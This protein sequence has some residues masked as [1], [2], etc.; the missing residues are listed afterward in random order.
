[1]H[2]AYKCRFYPSPEPA[3]QF[4]KIFGSVR[5][6]DNWGL[7]TKEDAYRQQ[8]KG[9]GFKALCAKLPPLKHQAETVWLHEIPAVCLQQ[10]LRHLDSAYRK[11]FKKLGKH[12]KFHKKSGKQSASFPRTGF[13]WDGQR[14]LLAKMNEPLD[15]HWSQHLEG[16]P[17]SVTISKDKSDRYFGSFLVDEDIPR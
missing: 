13:K 16:Q 1:M 12:P 15:I 10:A 17:S 8:E 7:A 3:R 14:L 5:Y 11:F 4:A 2:K 6:I 9:I